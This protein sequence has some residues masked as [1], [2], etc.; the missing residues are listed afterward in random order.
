MPAMRR[1]RQEASPFETPA[2]DAPRAG[3]APRPRAGQTT[4]PAVPSLPDP[5]AAPT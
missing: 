2:A 4:K 5:G 3:T 1:T